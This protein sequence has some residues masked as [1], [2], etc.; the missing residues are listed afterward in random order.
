ML[1]FCRKKKEREKKGKGREGI[2]SKN[3]SISINLLCFIILKSVL[4]KKKAQREE[5][6]I[7]WKSQER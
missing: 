2:K 5:G 6:R 7:G 1:R 4:N 3:T